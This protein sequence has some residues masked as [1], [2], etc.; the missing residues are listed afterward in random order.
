MWLSSFRAEEPERLSQ[1]PSEFVL[2]QFVRDNT[3]A[4][5]SARTMVLLTHPLSLRCR[6][7]HYHATMPLSSITLLLG[8]ALGVGAELGEC[9]RIPTRA[10]APPRALALHR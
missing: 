5:P 2:E 3:Q 4:L 9:R 8:A 1:H 10:P 6:P 7:S